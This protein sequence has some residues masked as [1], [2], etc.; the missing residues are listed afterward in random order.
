M[1]T[2]STES[3][4]KKS[5]RAEPIDVRTAKNGTKSYHFMV[6]VGTKPDGTRDRQR[7]TFRDLPTAR[8]EYR[9]ITTEVAE[10]R[11]VRRTPLTVDEA[12]E[13]WLKNRRNLR[14]ISTR[15][16]TN[17]L[18]PV[19][20]QLGGKKL[21]QVT[22]ADVDQLVRWMET[23]GRT[24][25]R[26]Y[27]DNG[28]TARVVGFLTR[29]P[30]GVAL[31]E[32]R[33]AFPGVDVRAPLSKLVKAGR[34]ERISRGVYRLTESTAATTGGVKPVTIRTTLTI[35]SSVVQSYVDQE[36]L[37]RNVV[38]LVERP[39]DKT[40]DD[41]QAVTTAKSWTLAEVERFQ[42]E[43]RG[44]RLYACW[45]L[46]TYGMRR[47][48]IMGLRW[49]RID[50]DVLMVRRGRVPVDT[51][52]VE[53]G[54]KSRRSRRDLP[55]PQDVVTALRHLKTSQKAEALAQGRAWSD[56]ALIAVDEQGEPIRP[57]TYSEQWF[58]RIRERAGL[59][60]I[61]LRGLRNSSVSLMLA[62]GVPV[63]VVAAW[64]GHSPE[65]S[66][67]VY[68]VAQADDLRTASTALFA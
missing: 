63:H 2:P 57:D 58:H 46:S 33:D 42:Q 50:G 7:F 31:R 16:Y 9:R 43:A 64:H 6:D 13:E 62:R 60:R 22:K 66:L 24:E 36:L 38:K 11:Y 67:G 19:C 44:E 30:D 65:M 29:H 35:F 21:A 55:L 48:E 3:S 40:A 5:R 14:K 27:R 45:L 51:E 18:K 15:S 39:K 59:R 20:R 26:H 56:D 34:A 37:P 52:V 10:N 23:Q 54:P 32:V 68:A 47:S 1:T 17:A 4:S 28:P 8:R 49:S 25:V 41:E 53:D 12:C 61:Q